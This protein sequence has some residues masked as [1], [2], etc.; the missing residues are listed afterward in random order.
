MER[1]VDA[2]DD[3]REEIRNE[4]LLLLLHLTAQDAQIQNF[5]AFRD[6]FPRLFQIM[7][8]EGLAEGGIIVQDCLAVVNQV[9]RGNEMTQKLF[10]QTNC[11][12][13]L[14]SLLDLSA[15]PQNLV[16]DVGAEYA[17]VF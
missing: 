12:K 8:L 16:P 17:M 3:R 10:A 2:L 9:L 7:E 6:G 11:V 1:L 5:V 15:A 14:P 13:F 4:M